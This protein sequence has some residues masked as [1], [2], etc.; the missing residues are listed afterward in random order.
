MKAHQEMLILVAGVYVIAAAGAALGEAIGHSPAE[1]YPL[2]IAGRPAVE[3]TRAL[4][5]GARVEAKAEAVL[6]DAIIELDIVAH[7]ETESVSV[8]PAGLYSGEGEAVGVL[9]EDRPGVI[10]IRRR[11]HDLR[12]AKAAT[13]QGDQGHHV[14][15]QS[16]EPQPEVIR[17]IMW[18]DSRMNHSPS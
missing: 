7:L 18:E 10:P 13:T 8:V 12:Q 2:G 15:G 5:P 14:G 4:R 1:E 6:G 17:A 16:N 9:K 11:A 3:E